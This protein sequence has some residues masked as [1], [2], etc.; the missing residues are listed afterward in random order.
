MATRRSLAAKYD[1]NGKVT[2]SW[3]GFTPVKLARNGTDAGGTGPWDTDMLSPAGVPAA[4]VAASAFQFTGLTPGATY[5]LYAFVSKS[6]KL[7][8]TFKVPAATT[9]PTPPPVVPTF[10]AHDD[11]GGKVTVSWTN[12]S[13]SKLGRDGV[14]STGHGA[15]DTDMNTPAGVPA[16]NLASKSFQFVAL[17]AGSTYNFSAIYSGGTAAATVKVAGAVTPPPPPP[18][19]PPTTPTF[20]A[21]DDGAG[22]VTV[23]WTNMTPTKLGRDGTDSTG[24][25]AWDTDSESFGGVPAASQASKS[26]QFLALNLGTKYTFT[27]TYSGGTIDASVTTAGSTTTTPPPP[28]PTGGSSNTYYGCYNGY[29]L[30]GKPS[31]D[32]KVGR[33]SNG[34]MTYVETH[35]FGMVDQLVAYAKANPSHMVIMSLNTLIQEPGNFGSQDERDRCRQIFQKIGQAGVAK[36]FVSRPCYEFNANYGFPWQPAST[37]GDYAGAKK[38]FSDLTDIARQEAPGITI[39]W[40]CVPWTDYS[41]HTQPEMMKIFPGKDKVDIC[42]LDWYGDNQG[43]TI[44]ERLDNGVRFA[45]ENLGSD[46]AKRWSLDEWANRAPDQQNGTGDAAWFVQYGME[47]SVDSA[48]H[49]NTYFDSSDGGV[50]MTLGGASLTEYRAQYVKVPV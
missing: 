14:D 19:P 46:R 6:E 5:L 20:T 28:P 17:V 45:L 4:A 23:S 34:P 12:M 2:L 48:C 30:S 35:D 1:G 9:V 40:C 50:G 25:P 37:G 41:G 11:G 7:T 47:K 49:H 13:P 3:K 31:W 36:Q 15:W 44:T 39:D 18:P 42:G 16:A 26:F 8:K 27:A 21:H 29:G 33:V 22:K 24:H 10:T 32:N 38:F 43:A